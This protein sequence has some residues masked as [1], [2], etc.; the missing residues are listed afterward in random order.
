MKRIISTILYTLLPLLTF[1]D[2]GLWTVYPSYHNATRCVVVDKKAYVVSDGGLYSYDIED[3]SV[4]TYSTLNLMSDF[5]IF[6]IAYDKSIKTLVMLYTNGNIDLLLPNGEVYNITDLKEKTLS[7]KTINDLYVESGHAYISTN[8]GLVVVNTAKRVIDNYYDLKQNVLSTFGKDGY[9]YAAAKDGVYEGN[10]SDNLLD[11]SNWKKVNN[12]AIRKFVVD[13]NR[14]YAST[15]NAFG[16]VTVKPGSFQMARV[17][18]QA[19]SYWSVANEQLFVGDGVKLFSLSQDNQLTELSSDSVCTIA[20]GEGSYWAACAGKGLQGMKLDNGRL[21]VTTQ[22]VIPESPIRNYCASLRMEANNRLLIAGGTFNFFGLTYP[23]TLMK[24]ENEKFTPFEEKGPI[25]EMTARAYVKTTD[26]VQDPSD[27][28][29][30]YAS[31]AMSGLYEFKNYKYVRHYGCFN[32]PLTSILPDVKYPEWYVWITGLEFDDNNNLWMLN[33]QTDTIIRVKKANGGWAALYY[34][35]IAG[36]QSL[37]HIVF[38]RRGWAWVNSRRRTNEGALAGLFCLNYNGTLEDTSDDTR[39]FLTDII[40]Q[41]GT[42]YNIDLLNSIT[43]D[44]NGYM[45]FGTD[46]GLFMTPTP[47]E[48][49]SPDFHLT[50]IKVPRNDGTNLADYLLNGVP[51]NCV[52]ID[53]GNRKWVGTSNS[54]V[55]LISSDG[56]EE[57]AHFTTANSPLISDNVTSIAING[58]SGTVFFGSEAGLVSY[59]GGATDPVDKMKRNNVKVFPNPVSPEYTGMINITG[60]A[61]NSNV[62]IVSAAGR[63]VNEGTSSGGQYSWNGLNKTGKRCGSGVYFVLATDEEGKDGV[64]QRFVIIR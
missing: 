43:E 24:Y 22:S 56:L 64:A 16:T 48:F 47:D 25:E 36:I 30:H 19:F 23:G 44:I 6:D 8:S 15:S 2:D 14:V 12:T 7:D 33:N 46:K 38:D 9:L 3:H 45:W 57:L 17:A 32:S 11:I 62:K 31:S 41:D 21:S 54:G 10:T 49:F 40:N 34:N 39:R 37:D 26:L 42:A 50:Q 27:P 4:E 52:T 18:A 13:G 5:N 55:Y 58:T 59:Q 63:L 29:H 20:W 35:E 1:A 28:E 51:V 53:G 61:Y 60:L